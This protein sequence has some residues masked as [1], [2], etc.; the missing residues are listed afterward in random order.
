M[1]REDLT[2]L[3]GVR[4]DAALKLMDESGRLYEESTGELQPYENGL[5]GICAMDIS[6]QAC[7]MMAEGKRAFVE[8][9]L[10]PVMTDEELKAE[11]KKRTEAFPERNPSELLTSLFPKKLIDHIV[12]PVDTRHGDWID[13][14]CR[15]IKHQSF[16]L[17]PGMIDDFS[18]AQ[19]VTGG[20][21]MS[22]IDDHCMLKGR[23]GIYVTGELLD[24]DGIC[25]GYNLH[26]AW[27]TGIIAGEHSALC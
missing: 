11:I 2:G 3:K 4:C 6:G 16:E 14:L 5:S 27:M 8:A 13:V 24:T 22:D 17:S 10:F 12:H 25:G 23:K 9:D 19:T 26:F 18:R 1:V 20:V 21:P 7:R 15:N